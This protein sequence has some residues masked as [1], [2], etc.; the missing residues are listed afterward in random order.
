MYLKLDIYQQ[1]IHNRNIFIPE[2][3]L[4]PNLSIISFS[5]V[6]EGKDVV[7]L[8]NENNSKINEA[9]AFVKNQK[10]DE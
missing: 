8:Q 1:L 2:A 4:K 10:V 9:I 6:S 3:I 7:V 5:V